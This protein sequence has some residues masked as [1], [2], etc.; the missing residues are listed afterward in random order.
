VLLRAGP[1]DGSWHA[2]IAGEF[3]PVARS[4]DRLEA[5]IRIVFGPL[6]KKLARLPAWTQLAFGG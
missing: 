5:R 2:R 1:G 6:G 3:Y 4:M